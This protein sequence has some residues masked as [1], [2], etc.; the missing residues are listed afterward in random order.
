M[1]SEVEMTPE[2]DNKSF[3]TRLWELP[4]AM[5]AVGQLTEIYSAVKER[6]SVT[7]MA[8]NAGE[9]TIQMANAATKPIIE[10]ANSY[11]LSKPIV[12]T[13]ECAAGKIDRVASE[14]LAKVEE[15][16]PIITKTPTE[17]KA[18]VTN[19][20]SEYF[21]KVQN[22]SVVKMM[23][24]TSDGMFNVT[25]V[26]AEAVLPTDGNC[27]EDMKELETADEDATKGVIVRAQNLKRMV[28][29]R[30]TRKLKHYKNRGKTTLMSYGP[31][32]FSVDTVS[33]LQ[34]HV[35]SLIGKTTDA[36]KK[37]YSA[38]MYIPNLAIGLTGEVVVSA[39]ELVFALTEAHSITDMPAAVA[40]VMV[41][42]V[43]PISDAKD[44]LVGHVFVPPQVMTTYLLSSRP[45]Q[46]IIPQIVSVEDMSNMELTVDEVDTTESEG[47]EN[48]KESS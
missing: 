10:A 23:V 14:T 27:E 47:N 46:W 24:A 37:V 9:S 13:V 39:K 40:N 4:V 43:Q 45:I 33:S 38:S 44:R 2:A 36:S 19:T 32:K 17:I 5:A 6:N 20:A 8:C 25:E 16:C 42:A 22:S 11:S 1:A 12:G 15:K 7:R 18:T 41:K 34:G 48:E 28:M 26:L 35:S 30:G 21:S 29:R 31:I 3:T